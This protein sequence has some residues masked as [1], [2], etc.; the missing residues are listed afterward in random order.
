MCSRNP[1][2]SAGMVPCQSGNRNTQC[3]AERMSS[4]A[5]T[6]PGGIAPVSNSSCVRNSGSRAWQLRCG[7]P[8]GPGTCTFCIGIGQR[9]QQVTVSRI[10]MALDDGDA[11][12]HGLSRYRA[13]FHGRARGPGIVHD[14]GLRVEAHRSPVGRASYL[15]QP[16]SPPAAKATQDTVHRVCQRLWR[17]PVQHRLGSKTE[18]VEHKR[19]LHAVR[20]PE[21]AAHLRRAP[22]EL[23]H[24]GG[25]AGVGGVGVGHT[26]GR[27]RQY[28]SVWIAENSSPALAPGYAARRRSSP[29]P[30]RP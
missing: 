22:G 28:Q 30:G 17:V 21:A 19:Y 15:G 29:A 10:W 3:S 27:T 11:S 4:R 24:V 18:G 6:S 13:P 12:C 23:V 25:G 9:V 2:N 7:A 1:L 20:R 26:D 8:H 5:W 14:A 16:R